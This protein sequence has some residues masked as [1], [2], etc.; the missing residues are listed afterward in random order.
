MV[1]PA[2]AESFDRGSMR[3]VVTV[4][5]LDERYLEFFLSHDESPQP[6]ISSIVLPRLAATSDGV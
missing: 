6:V 4:D 2:K 3:L 1:H 5:A